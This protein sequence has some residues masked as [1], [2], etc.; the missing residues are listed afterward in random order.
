VTVTRTP[1]PVTA[2]PD[3]ALHDQRIGPFAFRL[4]VLLHAE[5][6]NPLSD[7][8]DLARALG[9]TPQA[10]LGALRDLEAAG[11]AVRRIDGDW[12]VAPWE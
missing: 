7:E 9:Y 8:R 2:V 1:L 4:L 11:Y 6:T 12:Q 5:T 3:A 10:L